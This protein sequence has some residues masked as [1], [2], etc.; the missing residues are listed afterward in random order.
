MGVVLRAG[1]SG[2]CSS[3]RPAGRRC[4]RPAVARRRRRRRRFHPARRLSRVDRLS[5]FLPCSRGR[6]RGVWSRILEGGMRGAPR[7][8]SAVSGRAR[9]SGYPVHVA[10]RSTCRRPSR[11][12]TCC[13]R[14][15]PPGATDPH[16]DRRRA[17]RPS[18]EVRPKSPLFCCVVRASLGAAPRRARCHSAVQSPRRCRPLSGARGV[19][20][21]DRPQSAAMPFHSP[22]DERPPRRTS[23]WC[24]RR[25]SRTRRCP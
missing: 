20:A 24:G 7:M 13:R 9:G 17:R 4:P 10:T 2:R 6:A 8:R 15:K 22:N 1:S 25:P 14:R 11:W 23:C 5:R 21:V 3:G 18:R 19:R 12:H 16:L